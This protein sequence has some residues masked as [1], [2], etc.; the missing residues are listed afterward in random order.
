[1][2]KNIKIY[3]FV[4]PLENSFSIDQNLRK[5]AVRRNFVRATLPVKF[6]LFDFLLSNM[7]NKDLKF[8]LS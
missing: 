1:M 4:S 2:K 5:S 7:H 6:I 3:V 8:V